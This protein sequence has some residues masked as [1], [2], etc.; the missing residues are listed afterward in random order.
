MRLNIAFAAVFMVACSGKPEAD[1]MTKY[2]DRM[3]ACK[4]ITCAEKVFP[5]IEKWTG[6]H[7]GK[8]VNQGAAERYNTQLARA[9][10]C[11]DTLTAAPAT[12]AK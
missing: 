4:D 10:K 5:E 3:C 12:P 9:Q 1:Q 6:D 7:E 2:A 11:Y 8:E